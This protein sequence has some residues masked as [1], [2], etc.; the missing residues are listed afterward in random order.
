[1]KITKD[2]DGKLTLAFEKK[3]GIFSKPPFISDGHFLIDLDKCPAN[4]KLPTNET[5][6]AF[7]NKEEFTKSSD[8]YFDKTPGCAPAIDEMFKGVKKGYSPA[9]VTNLMLTGALQPRLIAFNGTRIW[10]D[11]KYSVLFEDKNIKAK[12]EYSMVVTVDEDTIVMPL[13]CKHIN[14]EY[15][16]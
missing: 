1:M 10:I 5:T 7:I 11:N 2:R 12:D 3:D 15:V 16:K 4:V 14:Q 13:N 8:Q 6:A 9:L